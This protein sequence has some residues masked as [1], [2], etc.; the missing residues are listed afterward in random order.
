MNF[1][2]SRCMQRFLSLELFKATKRNSHGGMESTEKFFTNNFW[3]LLHCTYT[4]NCAM[5][6]GCIILQYPS[7]DI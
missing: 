2:G 5:A 3:C 7:F 6:E 1:I 4:Y